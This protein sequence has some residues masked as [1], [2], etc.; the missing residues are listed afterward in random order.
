MQ[1][2]CNFTATFFFMN[3]FNLKKTFGFLKKN[4]KISCNCMDFFYFEKKR[5][6]AKK[7]FFFK[8]KNLNF[9]Y[10]IKQTK[11][12]ERKKKNSKHE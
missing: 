5:I 2:Q 9:F 4:L 6:H 10:K 3:S 11:A 8:L 1:L 12:I 7:S